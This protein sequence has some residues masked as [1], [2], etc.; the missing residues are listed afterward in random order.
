MTPPPNREPGKKARSVSRMIRSEVKAAAA[1]GALRRMVI[2]ASAGTGKTFQLSSRYIALLRSSSPEQ[3]LASTFTRKAAGEILERVLLRLAKATV[4]SRALAE[5]QPEDGSAPLMRNECRRLLVDFTRQLHRVRIGTLDAFFGQLAGSY[6]LELG[7]PPGWRIL[8]P[9]EVGGLRD[10]AIESMLHAGAPQDLVQL[11]H[12]LDKGNSSR[13]ISGLIRQTIDDLYSVFLGTSESCWE[14][15][16]EHHFL[17]EEGRERVL[18]A[19]EEQALPGKSLPGARD[20]DCARA[21]AGNWEEFL[22]KGLFPGIQSGTM[23]YR[24]AAIPEVLRRPYQ[25]LAEHALAQL[26]TVWK[27][28]TLAARQLLK[29]FHQA[30]E[31]AKADAGGLEFGDITRRLEELQQ[32]A[33][34]RNLSY[35]LDSPIEHVLLDEFQDTSRPQWNVIRPLAEQACTSQSSSF[36]CVGDTKQAIYGWRGGEAAI[37]DTIE[38]QLPGLEARPLNKSYRSSPAVIRAVNLAMTRLDQHDNFDDHADLLHRWCSE[39]PRHETA[40]TDLSGYVRLITS[41]APQ[42]PEEGKPTQADHEEILW[43][44]TAEYVAELAAQAPEATIGVLTRKNATV[45]RLIFELHHRRL[46]A[47]EEGGN[48]LTDSAAV[49]LVLS[50]LTLADHPGH[51]IARYHV[52]SSPLGPAWNYLDHTDLARTQDLALS[53]RQR[54]LEAGYGGL[55]HQLLSQLGP[56]CDRREERRLIQLAGLADEFDTLFPSLRPSEFV[57]Y[58]EQQR[59]EEPTNA[60]IRVMNVHQSKG[61]EFDI[62]VLPQLDGNLLTPPRYVTRSAAP[63]EAP[64]LVAL[65]RNETHFQTLGGS[66]LEAREQTLNRILQE[67]LCLLYVAMTRAIRSLHMIISPKV[68]AKLPKSFAGLLRAGLAPDARLA[69]SSV[70]FEHGDP[71]WYRQP[72][73]SPQSKAAPPL[74][75]AAQPLRLAFQ[76]PRGVRR[77]HRATPSGQKGKR[78]VSLDRVLADQSRQARERG[79]QFHRWLQEIVWSDDA[80]FEAVMDRLEAATG[81][82][83]D[84]FPQF[85]RALQQPA[86]RQVLS[87]RMYTSGDHLPFEREVARRLLSAPMELS[88]KREFPF[89]RRNED[90]QLIA[91]SIDRLVILL[92]GERPVAADILDFKTDDVSSGTPA[93]QARIEAYRGQMQAYRGAMAEMF[94]LSPEAISTRLVFL[95]PGRVEHVT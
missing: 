20:K 37:F 25:L 2:R 21:R 68:S 93:L 33:A 92:H 40:R 80:S 58:V 77:W 90:G 26:T 74:R 72:R 91:G 55:V 78:T 8:D 27:H 17:T 61:L 22:G 52:A 51:T 89:V 84:L 23:K 86:V 28:Q 94:S 14:R 87:R 29:D 41:P 88:L 46:D 83:L 43:T 65:Y 95:G 35:R 16:P 75:S 42:E 76:P 57:A 50:L 18:A 5:L 10:Q 69:P 34:A 13:S 1:G 12:L 67:Q 47:S 54:L 36:F 56:A 6:A 30:F 45:G 53:I 32:H 48:P 64:D 66:L 73:L 24:G 71:N 85:R 4:D 39:F 9:S 62:V 81:P 15:F 70:L 19:I 49:Q 44:Y 82:A 60:R 63:G 31:Q 3:I 38:Q 59:R 11:M 7:L 79:T